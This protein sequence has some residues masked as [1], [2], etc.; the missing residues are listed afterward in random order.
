MCKPC[1]YCEGRGY[2]KSKESISLD[3]LRSIEKEALALKAVEVVVQVHPEICDILLDSLFV[4]LE[5]LEKKCSTAITV[6]PVSS[7]HMEDYHI[8]LK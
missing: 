5:E 4:D 3:I 7:L 8:N 1:E 6:K 2:L